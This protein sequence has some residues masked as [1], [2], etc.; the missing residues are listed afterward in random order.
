[1]V[2]S[3]KH[4]LAADRLPAFTNS[5]KLSM[6]PLDYFQNYTSLEE[7]SDKLARDIGTQKNKYDHNLIDM[8][9]Y[10]YSTLKLYSDFVRENL[11]TMNTWFS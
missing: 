1:M 3:R 8:K 4:G 7:Y 2:M 10:I 5:A 6:K 11:D 9:E